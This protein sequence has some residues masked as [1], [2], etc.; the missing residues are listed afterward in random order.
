MLDGED[1]SCLV[2]P[3]YTVFSGKMISKNRLGR[4]RPKLRQLLLTE[5]KSVLLHKHIK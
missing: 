2:R 5:Y 3:C 1:M 4:I